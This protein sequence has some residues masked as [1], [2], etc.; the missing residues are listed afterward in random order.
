MISTFVSYLVKNQFVAGILFLFLAW[1]VFQI[2][3]VVLMLFASYI[4]MAALKPSVLWLQSQRLPRIAAIS[5]PYLLVLLSLIIL[6]F[7]LVP[8]FAEQIQQLFTNLPIFVNNAGEALGFRIDEKNVAQILQFESV[9]KN[10]F[11]F[12]GGVV[13]ALFL[14]IA[15]FVISFYMLLEYSSV[16]RALLELFPENKR[17]RVSKIIEQVD[18]KLGV[19]LRGQILLSLFVGLI[20]WLA[21]IALQLGQYAL[22]LA[23]LAG[24][25]EIIPT[26]G[27]IFAAI[28]AVIIGLSISPNLA[29]VLVL[30]YIG[31]QLVENN[32]LVPRIMQRAVGMSPI[33]VILGITVGGK[34]FGIAGA[35]LSIPLISLLM[36]IYKN[37]K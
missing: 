34:F 6:I 31:I 28:P 12:A 27:P 23:L 19:W 18:H 35:L 36:I 26:I 2:K 3:E 10:A 33:A 4:I 13:G 1:I 32:L 25:L 29:L 9:S 21:L 7:P 22:P 11:A 5:I 8:F 16:E 37:V 24:M 17:G 30:L 20:T 14:I 15:V